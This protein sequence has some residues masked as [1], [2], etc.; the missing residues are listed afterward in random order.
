MNGYNWLYA[1]E[2]CKEL[3][4]LDE[5]IE[6]Q[7]TETS[8]RPKSL[9]DFI[10]QDMMKA[11]LRTFVEAAKI[12]GKPLGHIL[13][14]GPPGLGKTSLGSLIASEMGVEMHTTSGPTLNNAADLA[15]IITMM[16]DHDILF[17][18]EI[19]RLSKKIQECLYSAMEDYSLDLTLGSGPSAKIIKVKLPK[20]TLIGATTHTGELSKP[21]LDRFVMDCRMDLYDK[22]ALKKIVVRAA[23]SMDLGITDQVAAG[24]ARR[25]RGTPRVA[26]NMLRRLSDYCVMLGNADEIDNEVAE[27]AFEMEGIDKE[28]L[29]EVERKYLRCLVEDFQGGPVG[30]I[31]LSSMLGESQSSVEQIEAYLIQAGM[32]IKVDRG[33]TATMKAIKHLGYPVA[34]YT[35]DTTMTRAG[36]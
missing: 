21:M 28:G 35:M 13:F 7:E 36:R 11:R 32:V 17:V 12:T 2:Q 8:L 1:E 34:E 26:I 23:A 20:F 3:R 33:R 4:T 31:N 19:H 9:D 22:L 14:A 29:G 5:L 15:A 16:E 27:V 18:D 24:V 30:V 25:S 10:G 6:E